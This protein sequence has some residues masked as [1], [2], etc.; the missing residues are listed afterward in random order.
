[1]ISSPCD[2]AS[3]TEG[4][5]DGLGVTTICAGTTWRELAHATKALDATR[6]SDDAKR[7]RVRIPFS[8]D[9]IFGCGFIVTKVVVKDFRGDGELMGKEARPVGVRAGHEALPHTEVP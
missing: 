7:F 2:I 3:A 4:S 8:L 1:M 5:C 9:Q 6:S